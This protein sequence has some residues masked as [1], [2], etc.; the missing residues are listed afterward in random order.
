MK[1]FNIWNYENTFS[2]LC[3]SNDNL[4]DKIHWTLF[5]WQLVSMLWNLLST[6]YSFRDKFRSTLKTHFLQVILTARGSLYS[7]DAIFR[8]V[9]L[10]YMSFYNILLFELD[11]VTLILPDLPWINYSPKHN[12][13]P[14]P[15]NLYC[16]NF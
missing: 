2:S 9:H 11:R 7:L 3:R 16:R 13:P 5:C 1:Q 6:M 12:P 8:L 14:P 15:H 10:N 4:I